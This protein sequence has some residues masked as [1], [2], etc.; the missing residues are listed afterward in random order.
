MTVRLLKSGR[1]EAR[2]THQGR[3]YSRTWDTHDQG[4]RWEQRTRRE[5]S[6]GTYVDPV[7]LLPE[8][9][10]DQA[11]TLAEYAARWVAERPLKPR[12]RSEYVRMLANFGPLNGLRVDQIT[13]QQVKDWYTGLTL[14]STARKHQYE[15]L[16]AIFNGV[17]DDELRDHSPVRIA[18]AAKPSRKP[19]ADIPTPGQIHALAE[20]M[21]SDK[22]RVMVLVSAWCGLRFGESTELRRKDVLLDQD[23][24]P[25][26]LRVR[27]GVVRVDGAY[28]VGTPKSA[29]GMRDVTI[30]PHV[31]GDVAAYLATLPAA[32]E[33]L[34][35][36]GTRNGRHMA[37]SSLYKPF[38]RARA[39]VGLPHL[40]WHDLRHFSAT[41]AAMT[42]ATLAE[43]QARLGH[44][45]VQAAMRYQHAAAGRDAVIAEA[46]SNVGVLR[47]RATDAPEPDALAPVWV[48]QPGGTWHYGG[49]VPG[50]A[51]CGRKLGPVVD[52]HTGDQP[53]G[54]VCRA[55]LRRHERSA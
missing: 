49:S 23:G 43:L 14:A 16:R 5:L 11:P 31:R 53:R 6:S 39:V 17:V 18:G 4:V 33:T 42:G 25:L 36:P 50:R 47:P 45:T 38:Y 40:R 7:T 24:T 35:F 13:R 10:P 22:Y 2:F 32:P 55:C 21:P 34:L 48:R 9:E 20:A 51:Y 3:A 52:Q 29:A 41:T 30:P 28:V 15:L 1:F 12:T 8:P 54:S 44:S 19:M 37:P 27:R 46:M 26:A